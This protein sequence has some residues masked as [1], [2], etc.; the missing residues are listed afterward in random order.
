MTLDILGYLSLLD[1]YVVLRRS[2]IFPE[3]S[4]GSDIDILVEDRG[5][6]EKILVEH[7]LQVDVDNY[8]IQVDR[9][10][11]HTHID[12]FAD[13]VLLLRFDLIDSFEFLNKIHVKLG[14][15]AHVLTNK[16]RERIDGKTIYFPAPLDDMLIRYLEYIE[17]FEAIPT[18]EKHL[19]YV[20]EHAAAAPWSHFIAHVHRFTKL[21][22]DSYVENP[23]KQVAWRAGVGFLQCSE[24]VV[25]RLPPAVK[26]PLKRVYHFLKGRI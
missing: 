25:R 3:I 8:A 11:A 26:K 4:V 24:H 14:F 12:L 17:Y 13:S 2:D 1:N 23:N 6:A 10:E 20:L 15:C 7:F 21:I 5:Y 16:T 22:H 9:R 18:K 19:S